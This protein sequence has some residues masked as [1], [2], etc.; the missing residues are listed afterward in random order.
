MKALMILERFSPLTHFILIGSLLELLDL[1][2]FVL[3][4]S[5]L[6]LSYTA[7]LNYL[8]LNEDN[9]SKAIY[10]QP[11]LISDIPLIYLNIQ[12]K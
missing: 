6:L 1:Q 7:L 2:I 12:V 4:V 5:V 11:L 8:L 3:T 10:H 9:L